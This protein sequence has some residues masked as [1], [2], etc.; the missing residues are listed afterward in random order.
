LVTVMMNN[1]LMRF[2]FF[3]FLAAFYPLIRQKT[4]QYKHSILPPRFIVSWPLFR[5]WL[6]CCYYS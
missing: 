1:Y 6:V 4:L 5:C 3:R 2:N